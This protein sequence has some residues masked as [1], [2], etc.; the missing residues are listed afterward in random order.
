MSLDELL[1][2]VNSKATFFLFV[3]ALKEDRE[4]EDE[5]EKVNPSSPYGSG[6]NGWENGTISTFLDAIEA[7][8]KDSN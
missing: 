1:E 3:K 8:G 7:F 6:A 2:Q 4:S 5:T